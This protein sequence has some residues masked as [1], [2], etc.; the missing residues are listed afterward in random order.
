MPAIARSTHDDAVPQRRARPVTAFAND[1][2]I[3]AATAARIASVGWD[4]TG[5]AAVGEGA[6]LTY[7]A[8]YARYPDKTALGLGVWEESLLPHL[9]STLEALFASAREARTADLHEHLLQ[10]ATPDVRLVAAV[11]LILAARFEPEIASVADDAAA[12]L[13]RWMEPSPDCPPMRA[14][15]SAAV[16]Y[17]SFGLILVAGRP[18]VDDADLTGELARYAEALTHPVE[19]RP[20]PPDR[21]DFIEGDPYDTGDPRVDRAIAAVLSVTGEIGYHR[22]TIAKICRAADITPG[23]LYKRYASKLDLFLD[24]TSRRLEGG[25]AGSLAFIAEVAREHGAGIAEAV[26][27]RESQRPDFATKRALDLESNR[28]A[29]YDVRM[30][31]VRGEREQEILDQFVASVTSDRRATAT[32]YLHT[33]LALGLGMNIVSNLFPDAWTLPFN[34]ATEPLLASRPM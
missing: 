20:L 15:V 4:E 6:G 5:M 28:L 34:C 13:A 2:A 18:W 12:V 16:A 24:A 21:A 30:R 31:E 3:T 1:S 26:F 33:E 19:P 11:E 10:V 9:T 17:I 29:T 7:G 23:F 32:A 14:A 8:V 22:A 25:F 27:W